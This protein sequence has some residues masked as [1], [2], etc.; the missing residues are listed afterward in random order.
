MRIFS[1]RF[2]GFPRILLE[3]V[4]PQISRIVTD[5]FLCCI[6]VIRA[7]RVL[8]HAPTSVKICDIRGRIITH[9]HPCESVT[10]VG[11]SSA[12][13]LKGVVPQISQ[14]STDFFL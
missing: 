11:D 1:H 2:H 4:V 5:F 13:F 6:R 7:I 9:P 14:I 12:R 8:S 10:S 3:N